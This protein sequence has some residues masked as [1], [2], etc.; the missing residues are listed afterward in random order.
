MI[1][2]GYQF[3]TGMKF[4]AQSA[5]A[6]PMFRTDNSFR[7]KLSEVLGRRQ[8]VW[9]GELRRQ[10][11]LTR[12]SSANETS[13]IG[14]S[15]AMELPKLRRQSEDAVS[16]DEDYPGGLSR[17]TSTNT[18][19]EEV[20]HL[21]HCSPCSRV[22]EGSFSM[23][24]LEFSEQD[25]SAAMDSVRSLRLALAPELWPTAVVPNGLVIAKDANLE[26]VERLRESRCR[27]CG[28]DLILFQQ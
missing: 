14:V 9:K 5:L 23:E 16:L 27:S 10:R 15:T 24:E 1:A 12:C 6:L 21:H 4:H 17:L 19:G 11:L 18:A 26:K 20:N 8:Y 7:K 2:N 3:L 28:P 25:S 13:P 22:G